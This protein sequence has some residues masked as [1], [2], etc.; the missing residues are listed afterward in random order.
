MA[1]ATKADKTELILKTIVDTTQD[2]AD[3]VF[4]NEGKQTE[5][6]KT[7]SVGITE[8]TLTGPDKDKLAEL[9]S[10]V[11][12]E[13]IKVE[14]DEDLE[15]RPMAALVITKAD[16]H[17]YETGVVVVSIGDGT[18]VDQHG[19]VGSYIKPS[20]KLVRPATPEEIAKI[21]AEQ[22]KGLLKEVQ[23]VFA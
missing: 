9:F 11:I 10:I 19:K 12:G 7:L 21:P 4:K 1:K 18:A 23:I 6:A 3:E 17:T 22:I 14:K 15:F 8:L 20:R 5:K 2:W 16:K 13:T